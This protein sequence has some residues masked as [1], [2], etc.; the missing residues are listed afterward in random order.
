MERALVKLGIAL[1]KNRYAIASGKE[2][3]DTFKLIIA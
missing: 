1:I 2:I 3:V